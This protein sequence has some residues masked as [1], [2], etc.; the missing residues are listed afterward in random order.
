MTQYGRNRDLRRSDD[1]KLQTEDVVNLISLTYD[2]HTSINHEQFAIVP[3]SDG[4][5]KPLVVGNNPKSVQYHNTPIQH[6]DYD[7]GHLDLDV[8]PE[9]I[10][11]RLAL[12][13]LAHHGTFFTKARNVLVYNAL[14]CESAAGVRSPAQF[15]KSDLKKFNQ[16]GPGSSTAGDSTQASV[17]DDLKQI[18]EDL[19]EQWL[20]SE[21]GQCSLRSE[22]RGSPDLL[23]TADPEMSGGEGSLNPTTAEKPPSLIASTNPTIQTER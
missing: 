11:A 2:Q 7:L 20:A 9:L 17:D 6:Q 4:L 16:Q 22:G 14:T 3:R 23:P 19:V 10:L 15:K 21:D 12:T 13:L 8:S 1:G 5:W 18:K